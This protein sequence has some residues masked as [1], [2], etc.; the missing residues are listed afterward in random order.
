M[1]LAGLAQM[2][3]IWWY[4][5]H[6]SCQR[7]EGTPRIVAPVVLAGAGRV[8]FDADV[9]LG[10]R[11]GPGFLAGYTYIEARTQDS[12]VSF[13]ESTHLNNGVAIVSEGPGISLGRRCVVGPGVHIY[14]SDF[15][16]LT[17]VERQEGTPQM[18]A[19]SIGDDVFI[20]SGATILKGV[21][22]GPGSVVGAGAV[23]ACDVPANAVVAGN[24]GRV[25]T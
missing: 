15:H 3:R 6:W 17:A 5:R 2:F 10:W 19:V 16:P 14:D 25:K 11:L 4:R 13:G 24:P 22:L 1:R 9:I 8:A 18:A 7:V 12:S 23:V 21:T 20:G